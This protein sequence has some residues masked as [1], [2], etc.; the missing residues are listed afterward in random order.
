M[1][2]EP[3]PPDV[4]VGHVH[5][6]VGDVARATAFYR[7]VLGMNVTAYGP[8]V[9][10]PAAFLAFGDYH[11]H[12][13]LNAFDSA[14][15]SPPPR[16]HTGL[17]H[18]AFVYPDVRALAAAIRRVQASGHP[19][20]RLIDHGGTISAYLDDPDGNGLELYV[21]RPRETWRDADGRPV[22]KSEPMDLARWL[23]EVAG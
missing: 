19:V 10:L 5:L 23:E 22:M 21:D 3:A 4:R 14:G 7:D 11:H 6:K 17:Y 12:V 1:V 2:S 18:V 16:G 20:Q 15:G 13:G 8:D 9:G